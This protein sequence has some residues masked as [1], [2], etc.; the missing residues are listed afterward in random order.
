[1]DPYRR[2]GRREVYRNPWV[3][4]E[5]HEIVHPTGTPGEHVLFVSP[6]PSGVLV[7]DGD[8]LIFADQPR[9][10]ARASVIEIVK[11][12]ADPGESALA[13]AQRELREE[14]GYT[15][16]TWTSLGFAY[17]IPSIVDKPV[18]L[19]VASD[20]HDTATD[21]ED[22]ERIERLRLPRAAAYAAID[23]GRINDAVTIVALARF[24]SR[25]TQA[26]QAPR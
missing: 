8:D 13:C 16:D 14:L 15:A 7:V 20:L 21:P 25:D 1:M 19:F 18:E 3:C 24:R 26:P 2:L 9:F 6:A 5:V 11:G 12:G 23:D 10:G 17:E 4:V 22:V